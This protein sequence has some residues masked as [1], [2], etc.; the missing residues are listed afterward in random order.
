MELPNI[1]NSWFAARGW[2]VRTH[3]LAML[4]A[5][6]KGRHALLTAPTGAGKTLAGFLPTLADLATNPVE[7]LHTLYISPLKALAVD[8]QRNLITPIAEMGLNI[9][10]ET[11]TGDTPAARKARQK[12]VPPHILLTTPESLA[13]LLSNPEAAAMMV[14]VKRVIIDEVHAFG[15]TKRGDQLMLCLARLQRLAPSL[16]RVGL[17]ATIADPESWAGWLAPDADAAQVEIVVAQGGADPAIDILVID[18]RIPWGGHNGRWAARA[19]MRRIESARLA[20]VFVNTRAVAELVFRDLWAE[21]DRSL[22]IGIHHGSLAPEARRKVE[23]AMAAGKL[24]AI[25]ATASLDLGLDWGDVDL[26]IQM[27]AP[28]GASRLL[29]RTG[30]ANH[31]MDEASRCLIVPGNR[32][33][34]L[35]ALAARDAVQAGELDPDGF[36]PGALD[37]LAQ[38][39]VGC[40]AAGPFFPDELYDE[41]KSAAPYAGVTRESFDAVLGYAATGGYAL[42][43]Y[44]RYQRL[45]TQPDGRLRLRSAALARQWRMNSGTIVEAVAM[46]VVFGSGKSSRHGRKLGQVEEYFAGQL[47]V[48]DSFMFAGQTLEVTGFEGA[49]IHVRMGRGSPKVPVYAGGRMPMT[50]RLAARVRGLMNDRARWPAMPDDVREWLAIQDRVSRLP[51]EDDVLV[52]TFQRDD[53]WYMVVYGFAG[54]PAHQTLGMLITQRMERAGLNPLGFVASDYAMACWSLEPVDDPRPLF[55][56]TVLE[57]ELAEWLA[58]SPFLRRAFRE[59]AII[60]GLIERVQPGVHKSGKAMSV[61]S[62]LIYDVLRRHEPDHLLLTAAWTDARG[63][64]T[65]IARLAALLEQ[66]HARLSHVRAAHVTPLAVPSLLTIGRERV[67]D[68]ADSALLLEAEALIAEAMRVD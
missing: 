57:D 16:Q 9:R 15:T 43:A 24:R 12:E 28:K 62:D 37:V 36:R 5:A 50:T 40:A 18:D 54:H 3:Q 51:G 52:E 27:G 67:G 7:G 45:V 68:S 56:P 31:R 14:G 8:V 53:R 44:E 61:S 17:S 25:V 41:V 59:V 21:N 26:V 22:P 46:N 6:A 13:N 60:G 10:V 49:D 2:Q 19:V 38:H 39:V 42:K 65:D 30:R 35:E 23:A 29:Q 58:A 33:E 64:L 47:R 63:K 34:Y 11:R 55:D 20:I 1:I 66:S 32:F 4:D 48:G